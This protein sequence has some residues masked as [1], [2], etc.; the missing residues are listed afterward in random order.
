MHDTVQYV[1]EENICTD[2]TMEE[3]D[4]GSSLIDPCFKRV[5]E[6]APSWMSKGS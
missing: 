2:E 6:K 3:L 1:F 4:D 5:Q